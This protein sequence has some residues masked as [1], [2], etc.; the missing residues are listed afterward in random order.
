MS[1]LPPFLKQGDDGLI[2]I[3]DFPAFLQSKYADPIGTSDVNRSWSSSSSTSNDFI[4]FAFPSRPDVGRLFVYNKQ[5]SSQRICPSCHRLYRI[6]DGSHAGV[7]LPARCTDRAEQIQTGLCGYACAVDMGA[8]GVLS[9]ASEQ[10]TTEE[11]ARLRSDSVKKTQIKIQHLTPEQQEAVRCRR[12]LQIIPFTTLTTISISISN[13]IPSSPFPS[14]TLSSFDSRLTPS[15]MKTNPECRYTFTP[16]LSLL[17]SIRLPI[18]S[19]LSHPSS[20]SCSPLPLS[21]NII[22]SSEIFS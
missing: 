22:S 8:T 20:F 7:Q 16:S 19:F 5:R 18:P 10:F 4:R 9:M 1:S 3:T 12:L 15:L 21:F 2:F 6:G 14:T 11:C 13:S 17:I